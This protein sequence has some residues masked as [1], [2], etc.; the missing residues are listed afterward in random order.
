MFEGESTR[1]LRPGFTEGD[2]SLRTASS[3]TERASRFMGEL[4]TYSQP[5][6]VPGSS[7]RRDSN[8]PLAAST[9]VA[10]NPGW[11]RLMVCSMSDPSVEAKSFHS[12]SDLHHASAYLMPGTALAS[13]QS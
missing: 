6:W 1:S 2:R 11:M 5:P 4:V 7:W 8:S 3:A 10:R 9:A 13:C 12:L